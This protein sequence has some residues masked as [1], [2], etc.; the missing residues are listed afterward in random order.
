MGVSD[1]EP[2]CSQ[3]FL[4]DILRALQ[5]KE[6]LIWG[7]AGMITIKAP[8]KI[9][10]FLEIIGRRLDGYHDI[11]SLVVPVSVYDTVRIE[12]R[13][14]RLS[15]NLPPACRFRGIPWDFSMGREEDNLVVRAARL[16]KEQTGC[17]KGAFISLSKRIPIGAGLGG[18]SADASAV[19]AGLN[20]L[21]KTGLSARDM[22]AIG[23]R[24]G[25]DVPALVHGGPIRL[26]GRGEVITP[27]ATVAKLPFRFL[28]VYPGFAISTADIYTR[29]DCRKARPEASAR[30]RFRLAMAGLRQCSVD[31]AGRGLFNAL[32]GTVFAKYPVLELI[33]NNLEKAGAKHVLLAGSGS[34]VFVL[35]EKENEGGPLIRCIRQAIELPLWVQVVH[36]I[37]KQD[38]N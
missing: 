5:H 30:K 21:W 29:F 14:S 2:D 4:F 37:G 35:L 26:E 18:G 11:R 25:S 36:A 8:G 34:T 19:I 20:R 32:Q 13:P 15:F 28:L 33:K 3:R 38:A 17:R 1:D 10:L 7:F 24:V 23:A 9:N 12:A 6:P 31:L 22:M 16:F 27:V